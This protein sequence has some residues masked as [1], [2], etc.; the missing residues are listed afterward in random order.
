MLN[1]NFVWKIS[2]LKR[3]IDFFH[4]RLGGKQHQSL[5]LR[6]IKD[7]NKPLNTLLNERLMIPRWVGQIIAEIDHGMLIIGVRRRMGL[8]QDTSSAHRKSG[9]VQEVGVLIF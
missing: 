2:A 3:C 8:R 1:E 4:I 9:V 5:P 7:L 6:Y